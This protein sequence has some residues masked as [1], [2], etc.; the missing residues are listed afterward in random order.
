MEPQINIETKILSLVAEKLLLEQE[1]KYIK[2]LKIPEKPRELEVYTFLEYADFLEKSLEYNSVIHKKTNH[3]EDLKK[4]LAK[5][6]Q[7][8]VELLPERNTWFRVGP[9]YLGVATSDWPMSV[10]ELFIYDV[11]N[12]ISS[13]PNIKH[14]IIN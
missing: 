12:P 7:A 8:I 10:P 1:L 2:E 11:T 9:Y 4:R 14:R 3:L 6:N 13:L 5:T